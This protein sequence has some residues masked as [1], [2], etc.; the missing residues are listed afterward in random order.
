MTMNDLEKARSN[1]AFEFSPP[2]GYQIE[3]ESV[4]L[5]AVASCMAAAKGAVTPEGD[6]PR[7]ML[8]ST[9]TESTARSASC[10]PKAR[11]TSD[12]KSRRRKRRL[13]CRA[14]AGFWV[15]VADHGETW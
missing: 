13:A 3:S 9:F 12:N 6:R 10:R 4:D 2:N 7:T 8:A 15:Q 11:W 5:A 14:G 1:P